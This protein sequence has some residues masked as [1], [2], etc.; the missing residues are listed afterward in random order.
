MLNNLVYE[1]EKRLRTIMKMHGLGDAAYWAIQVGVRGRYVAGHG[2]ALLC[3]WCGHVQ[4]A[5][6]GK[7]RTERLQADSVRGRSLRRLII[8]FP[9]LLLLPSAPAPCLCAVLLVLCH[10]L[11]LHLDPHHLWQVRRQHVAAAPHAPDAQC[12]LA[13]VLPL[14]YLRACCLGASLT[15]R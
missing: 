5:C 4:R 1:K 15:D 8:T 9:P 6:A 12:M 10:H 11:C 2:S 7:D 3:V 13:T 14:L